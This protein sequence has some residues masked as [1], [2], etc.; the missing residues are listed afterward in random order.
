MTA[1]LAL[2]TEEAL[3]EA[4][5]EGDERAFETLV[6][7]HGAS[8]LRLAR[9]FCG[10]RAVA[11]EVVQ[12][13]WMVVYT[14]IDRFEGRSSLSTWLLRILVNRA[15]TRGARERRMVPLSAFEDADQDTETLPADRFLANGT[16]CAGQWAAAPRPW[17]RPSD[18]L[19]GLEAREV[20]RGA[21]EDLTQSQ[22]VVVGLRDV[23]GLE[24]DEVAE[25]LG[26]N[27]G[28]VRV[29]LHRGRAKLRDALE[30]YVGE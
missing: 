3:V 13:T 6:D 27:P 30:D 24:T 11:E 23:D 15:K 18:R 8:M 10:S 9:T 20:L 17:D 22:R 2:T 1:T 14:G 7:R 26:T 29:L 19:L 21:M 25:M 28:H 4:L 16:A 12:E 5:R